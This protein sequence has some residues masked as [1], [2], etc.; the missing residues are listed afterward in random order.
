MKKILSF[1]FLYTLII[2]AFAQSR[3]S[4]SGYIKDGRNGE[5]LIGATLQLEEIKS[6]TISNEYGFYSISA[7]TGT[8]TLKVSYIGYTTIVQTIQLSE[9]QTLNFELQESDIVLEEVVITEKEA[10]SN[11][12]DLKMSS[13]KLSIET[14]RKLPQL[15][16]EVD[17]VRT[18]MLLP[19]VQNAGEGTTGFYVRGGGQDQNLILL[20]EAPVYNASHFL[21]FFSVFNSDAIKDVEIYK[22]GIP[23]QYGGRL[24]S[25]LDIRMKEGNNKKFAV[26]GGV[27]TISSRLTI[28]GP[29]LKDKA[30]FMISGRRTYADVFLKLSPNENQRNNKLYFY[31]LNTKINLTLNDKNRIY[32]S[33]YFGR[34]KFGFSTVFSLGWGNATGTLRWNHLFNDKLF[35]NTTAYF[36]NYDYELKI[37]GSVSNFKWTSNLQ[38][39]GVKQDFTWYVHPKHTLQYGVQG[40]YRK[41]LPGKIEP[42]SDKSIFNTITSDPIYGIETGIYI[43]DKYKLN[44]RI[45]VDAGLR[46]SS[47]YNMGPGT[48]YQYANNNPRQDTI[49]KTKYSSGKLINT[50]AGIEPRIAAMYLLNDVSSIKLNYNRTRQYI[51]LAT[52]STSALPTDVWVPSQ[53][54]VQPQIADQIAAGYFRNFK[55]NK[56]ETSMEIY[57]KWLTNQIDFRDNANVFFNQ[58]IETELLKGIG[59]AYGSEF[60]IKKQNGKTTGWISYTLS[61]TQRQ[62]NG[63]NNGNWYYA[64]YDRR[65]NGNIVITHQL[66]ERWSISGAFIYA[67]GNAVTFPAGRYIYEGNVVPYYTERNGFRF[68]AYHRADI[69]ATLEG[70]NKPNQKWKGSWNFSVYN[71]YMRKNAFSIF[72]REKKDNPNQTEAVMVYLFGI[73]PSVT[74]NFKF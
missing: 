58:R 26:T 19:G 1:I 11:V 9:R 62:I 25:L 68:P 48:V 24:S 52:N 40:A 61:F 74:Y 27:G 8:Y 70:K 64:R 31:D 18:M 63:I 36:S 33:G 29:I 69:S 30:S 7:P 37:G 43:S 3:V 67:T 4:I 53:R 39:T 6:G 54:Y 60:M 73:I 51:Q 10:S 72:F 2:G 13:E 46:F 16:G 38:E 22:G 55:Q 65:H 47:Y 59:R 21:G 71:I 34:D 49:G 50:Y 15:F 32:L 45:S 57:Y 66:T 42:T 44:K 56:F 23:A 20:D 5:S 41:F 14:I 28:E 35:S 17:V 12:T